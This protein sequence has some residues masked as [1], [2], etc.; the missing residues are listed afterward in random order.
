MSCTASKGSRQVARKQTLQYSSTVED[1]Y[2][3]T[4]HQS[5]HFP[6]KL[7]WN[8]YVSSFADLRHP[9]L[10]H[11]FSSNSQ[12]L[13]YSTEVA[14]QAAD[15]AKAML[16]YAKMRLSTTCGRQRA[17]AKSCARATGSLEDRPSL[18]LVRR[19]AQ[20]HRAVDCLAGAECFR[21]RTVYQAGR[22]TQEPS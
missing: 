6:S 9:M 5:P 17:G 13:Q 20:Q 11:P 18:Q 19:A 14:S 12:P 21:F 3:L 15:T 7:S 1:A 10:L 16:R 2:C 8:V 22:R 4:G